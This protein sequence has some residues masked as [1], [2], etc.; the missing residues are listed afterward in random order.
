MPAFLVES[1]RLAIQ[2]IKKKKTMN[3]SSLIALLAIVAV[4]VEGKPPGT[5]EQQRCASPVCPDAP[6]RPARQPTRWPASSTVTFRP[7]RLFATPQ[8]TEDV[9]RVL[10]Q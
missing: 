8:P 5:P 2:K 9:A 7:R 3:F 1:V 4:G 6:R 10:F